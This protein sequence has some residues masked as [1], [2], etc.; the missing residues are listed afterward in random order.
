MER[1]EEQIRCWWWGGGQSH[2]FVGPVVL[3]KDF[4][5]TILAA[6]CKHHY[7]LIAVGPRGAGLLGNRE[8]ESAAETREG[9]GRLGDRQGVKEEERRKNRV[10]GGTCDHTRE[11]AMHIDNQ[12]SPSAVGFAPEGFFLTWIAFYQHRCGSLKIEI[13]RASNSSVSECPV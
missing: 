4:L 1:R 13:K 10:G 5:G 9:G 11:D 8:R 3:L 2:R 12:F 6:I 7:H